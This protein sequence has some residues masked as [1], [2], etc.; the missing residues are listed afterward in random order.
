M[1]EGCLL[2]SKIQ[3]GLSS[4]LPVARLNSPEHTTLVFNLRKVKQGFPCICYS[5]PR[6][7]FLIPTSERLPVGREYISHST[8]FRAQRVCYKLELTPNQSNF[9]S[10]NTKT[11]QRRHT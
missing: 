1:T 5:K 6:I 4:S 10:L 7:T 11:D 3:R 2:N 8:W 9:K